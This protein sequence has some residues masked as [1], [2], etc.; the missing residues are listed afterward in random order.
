MKK[1]AARTRIVHTT[2]NSF[3]AMP[4]CEDRTSLMRVAML[5]TLFDM[6]GAT[7]VTTGAL[8]PSFPKTGSS[9]G[10]RTK[11]TSNVRRNNPLH[12]TVFQTPCMPNEK[13]QGWPPTFLTRRGRGAG[14][15]AIW[16]KNFNAARLQAG[17]A[18][19]AKACSAVTGGREDDDRAG[20]RV[21][22]GLV[23]GA[24]R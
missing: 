10:S 19:G 12:S 1:T 2:T 24:G 21:A 3:K 14:D 6:V 11:T 18:D 5:F 17:I 8:I 7:A 20:C 13:A 16:R 9:G 23:P 22:E 15:P 4:P